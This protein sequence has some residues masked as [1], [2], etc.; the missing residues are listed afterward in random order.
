MGIRSENEKNQLLFETAENAKQEAGIVKIQGQ[1]RG[2]KDRIKYYK[3]ILT[4]K[5]KLL[6]VIKII[7]NTTV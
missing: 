5:T 7:L 3:D 2:Y 6:Q 4:K 1:L